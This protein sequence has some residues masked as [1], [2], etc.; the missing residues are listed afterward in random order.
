MSMLHAGGFRNDVRNPGSIQVDRSRSHIPL[1]SAPRRSIE[2]DAGLGGTVSVKYRATASDR[3]AW[4]GVDGTAATPG[5]VVLRR[6]PGGSPLLK[7][8]VY[9]VS[10]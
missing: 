7:K 6:R 1:T 9:P 3:E 4:R 10:A 2:R 8:N 5:F